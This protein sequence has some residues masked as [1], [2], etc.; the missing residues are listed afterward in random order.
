[1]RLGV[2]AIGPG[3]QRLHPAV[4][5]GVVLGVADDDRRLVLGRVVGAGARLKI[6]FGKLQRHTRHRGLAAGLEDV[7]GLVVFMPP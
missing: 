2:E 6:G 7:E 3:G 4:G 1:V 5:R